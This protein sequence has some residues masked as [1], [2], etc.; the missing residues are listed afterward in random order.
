MNTGKQQENERRARMNARRLKIT[1]VGRSEDRSFP[2]GKSVR[3]VFCQGEV[4]GAAGEFAVQLWSR[5]G[6]ESFAG[7]EEVREGATVEG[8]EPKN[9]R[10]R[11]AMGVPVFDCCAG[12]RKGGGLA[13]VGALAEVARAFL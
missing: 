7:E 10:F 3:L 6:G 1:V 2:G 8:R 13:G 5:D 12:R 11:T 4:D 9:E